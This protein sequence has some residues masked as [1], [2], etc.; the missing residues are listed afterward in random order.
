MTYDLRLGRWERV[1]ADVH[2]DVMIT[3]APWSQTTHEGH[4][5][6]LE[7]YDDASRDDLPYRHWTEHDVVAFVRS[8][9]PRVRGWF[10]SLTDD[11]LGPVWKAA[12]AAEGRVVFPMLPF[13]HPGARVRMRGDGPSSWTTQIIVARPVTRTHASWGTLP[14]GYTLPTGL[15]QADREMPIVGGKP[16]WLLRRLVDDYSRPGDVIVDPCAG[17]GTTLLAAVLAGRRAVGAEAKRDHHAKAVARLRA[18]D[19][20]AIH[21][22]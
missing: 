11:V 22:A 16:L 3:D 4:A 17:A 9:S 20:E 13:I 18:I 15:D 2:A 5:Q 7:A 21:G 8:W 12:L 14:G 1:L 6:G 10:V 19:T